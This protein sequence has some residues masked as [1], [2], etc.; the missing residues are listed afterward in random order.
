MKKKT[1]LSKNIKS[2]LPLF[3]IPI[4]FLMHCTFEPHIEPPSS[5]RFSTQ[6]TIRDTTAEGRDTLVAGANVILQSIT[7]GDYHETLT[8]SFGVAL[9]SHIIPDRY[10]ILATGRRVS[11]TEMVNI[12]GQLQDTSLYIGENDTLRLEI[13]AQTSRSSAL[14]IS[15]IYY[16]G[17]PP[18][19]VPQYFHDQFL[20]IYNNSNTTLYLD[21]LIIADVEAGFRDDSLIHAIHAYMFPGSGTDYPIEPGQCIVIA[22][23]AID[24]SPPPINSLNLLNADFEYYVPQG[25]DVDNPNVTNMI[26]LHHK[27]GVDFLYSVF[28]DALVIIQVK[29]PFAL[30]Y[31]GFERLLL[32]KSGVIDGVE[33]RDNTSQLDMKRLDASIDAGLAGGIPSY[34]GKSIERKIERIED[35]RIIL[36][37]NNNSSL[38]FRILETPTPGYIATTE[39]E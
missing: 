24:H 27:Y 37:D 35:G 32:P 4:L 29:D 17:A 12:N 16:S 8:D 1:S 34:S 14:V 18:K 30:G 39:A 20:E 25:G 36:M 22:Q 15:E 19:P 6:I 2:G 38:D 11:I 28:R 3:I 7:Y 9:F 5:M 33:Y 31:D 21:S 13:I 23:D 10:N 26:Q